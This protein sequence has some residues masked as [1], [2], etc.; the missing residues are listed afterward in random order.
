[1]QKR[2]GVLRR[3]ESGSFEGILTE[4]LPE[5]CTDA[6]FDARFGALFDHYGIECPN[7]DDWTEVSRL[8]LDASKWELLTIHLA[9]DLLTC[10]SKA[11][12]VGRPPKRDFT[13]QDAEIMYEF[14]TLEYGTCDKCRSKPEHSL[15]AHA[16]RLAKRLGEETP[17]KI[18][19]RYYTLCCRATDTQM[20]MYDRGWELA[21]ARKSGAKIQS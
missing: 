9:F 14:F 13:D 7:T 5:Y 19:N 20:A 21:Q 12:P 4:P 10:M 18:K 16:R 6:D 15:N 1:M 11:R 8:R 17:V 2:S 3:P